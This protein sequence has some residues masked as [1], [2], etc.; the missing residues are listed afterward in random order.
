ML[1]L[2]H[3][4]I[5]YVS[6]RKWIR[7]ANYLNMDFHVSLEVFS[8]QRDELVKALATL[9]LEGWKRG[10]TFTATFVERSRD[11]VGA[12]RLG[13][14]TQDIHASRVA[15]RSAHANAPDPGDHAEERRIVGDAADRIHLARRHRA[16]T[17]A[18]GGGAIEDGERP[19]GRPVSE[20]P[21]LDLERA[22]RV[23]SCRPGSGMYSS[24]QVSKAA[25]IGSAAAMAWAVGVSA[26]SA[27]SFRLPTSRTMGVGMGPS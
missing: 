15:S 13:S 26:S 25:S 23:G 18:R 24:P 21:D 2:D 20:I 22:R 14:K 4:T 7:S 27:L 19:S 1:T 8:R 12:A 9:D 17:G 6:P 3:P 16:I 11:R 5:R 10:A